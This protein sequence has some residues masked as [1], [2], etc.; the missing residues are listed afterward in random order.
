MDLL[1]QQESINYITYYAIENRYPFYRNSTSS[2]Y[3]QTMMLGYPKGV[4][5]TE[6]LLFVPFAEDWAKVGKFYTMEQDNAT[7]PYTSV[8]ELEKMLG[9]SASTRTMIAPKFHFQPW[10]PLSWPLK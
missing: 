10:Q 8:E 9:S 3:P 7:L 2:F 5:D 1:D 4:T 6:I